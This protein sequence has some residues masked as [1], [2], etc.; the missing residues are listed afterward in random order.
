MPSMASETSIW[1]L[2]RELSARSGRMPSMDVAKGVR[3]RL[4]AHGRTLAQGQR[5]RVEAAGDGEM[6]LGEIVVF[7]LVGTGPLFREGA[8]T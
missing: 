6:G 5:C 3:A 4:I 7:A 1:Q 8:E 2:S